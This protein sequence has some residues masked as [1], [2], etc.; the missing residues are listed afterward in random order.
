M[1]K[2]SIVLIGMPGAGKTTMAPLLADKLGWGLIDTDDNIE[3]AASKSC[4]EIVNQHG[5]L[6]FLNLEENELIRIKEANHVIATGGSAIYSHAGMSHLRSIGRVVFMQI[7]FAD[8]L[9]R[10][11]DLENRGIASKIGQSFHATFAERQPLYQKYA[12]HTVDCSK[13]SRAQVLH[14]MLQMIES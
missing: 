11:L 12:D 1:R 9:K 14:E 5:Y 7:S 6:Y 2:N 10:K 3:S 4:Q 13:K 8:L